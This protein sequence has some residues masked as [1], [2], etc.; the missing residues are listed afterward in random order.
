M[1][2]TER[3]IYG[4]TD[5]V[6]RSVLE[7]LEGIYDIPP[8]RKHF[9]CE[10]AARAMARASALTNREIAL[11]T[12][13][14]G[15]V[16]AVIVGDNNK[17]ALF[18]IVPRRYLTRSS[19]I[20]CVHTH[21][22]GDARLSDV[23]ISALRNMRLDAMA[24]LAV[25]LDGGVGAA[26]A[27]T[28]P[29]NG[30]LT[31]Y[32]P[33]YAQETPESGFAGEPARADVPPA[34]C[35]DILDALD[36][37]LPII[38]TQDAH[39]EHVYYDPNEKKIEKAILVGARP[40]AA[41]ISASGEY[42]PLDELA[43]LAWT[44]GAEV[45]EKVLY[46]EREADAAFYIGKGKLEELVQIKQ[47]VKPDIIIFD[48]ELTGAQ[49]RNLEKELGVKVID[50]TALI[51]DIF[52][53]R[54]RTRE[55]KLQVEL[56]QL[57]YNLTRLT[58]KGGQ[59]SRLGGGIGTRGPGEKK[60]DVDRRHIRRRLH[61]IEEELQKTGERRDRTRNAGRMSS[62]P[63]AAFVGYT[64][65]GKS[66][67]FNALCGADV[68]IEDKLFATLDPTAR[69]LP[70]PSGGSV[71]AIDTVGFIDKLPHELVDA[72]KATLE[73]SAYADILIH[74]VDIA[75]PDARAQIEIVDRILSDIGASGKKTLIAF[76]KADLLDELPEWLA[77]W[78]HMPGGAAAGATPSS[79]ACV[80][81]AKTG[82][83]LDGLRHELEGLAQEDYVRLDVLIPY[84]EG[85][86]CSYLHE[87]ASVLDEEYTA[88][89]VS[90]KVLLG[91]GHAGWL[92]RFAV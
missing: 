81:S 51:L 15:I 91:K 58:G 69:K 16:Q 35:P 6:R 72:F 79:R 89:G 1:A 78:R 64:N 40:A 33:F 17:A 39:A 5:T 88:G 24:I 22:N 28:L 44:A 34:V 29:P 70:L 84:N 54:A 86:V 20:R 68:F 18:N 8:D 61:A 77:F 37:L 21:P 27:A 41:D 83:G 10:D 52:A 59:L 65:T 14:R 42:K 92:R 38:F 60:L 26:T 32:G 74:V 9:I 63:I 25:G 56:A 46:R 80:I 4:E 7:I 85:R 75:N 57:N 66:T 50:R 73:E 90:M 13:R 67:L 36:E 55:G 49:T 45:A 23:D 43:Q 76:N 11:M 47:E 12:D 30:E 71:I 2:K 48:E 3:K 53:G 31:V 62:M 87:N 19:G 82:Y